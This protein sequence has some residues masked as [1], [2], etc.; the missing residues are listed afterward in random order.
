MT[1]EHVEYFILLFFIFLNGVYIL[2]LLFAWDAWM[3]SFDIEK[4]NDSIKLLRSNNFPQISFV[5]PAFNEE[6]VISHNV[7]HL[8]N[9]SYRAVEIIVVNDGST[10]NMLPLMIQQ[11]NMVLAPPIREN[12]VPCQPIKAIYRSLTYPHLILV[13]KERGGRSD[14]LNG[15]INM[16]SSPYFIALDADTLVDDKEFNSLIIPLLTH[17]DTVAA[18][19]S[20]RVANGCHVALNRIVEFGFPSNYW[21]GIQCVEYLRSFFLG[22][23]GWS[24]MGGMFII[25]GAFGIFRTDIVIELKGYDPVIIAEDLDLTLRIHKKMMDSNTPYQMPFIPSPVAWTEVP[26]TFMSL[27]S[28]RERWQRGLIQGLWRHRDMLFNPR[29]GTLAFIVYPFYLFGEMLAPVVEF[30]GYVIIAYLLWIDQ[31]NWNFFFLFI[32]F[33]FGVTYILSFAS[34]LIEEMTYQKYHKMPNILKIL[35]LGTIEMFGYR[36]LTVLWRLCGFF[37]APISNVTYSSLKREGFN[38]PKK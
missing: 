16:V 2:Q 27:W 25:A 30:S 3:E 21:A 5:I 12:Q 37:P 36:Q 28:Q 29:Y 20:I 19:A 31:I 4:A 15:G 23:M 34:I 1:I 32:A 6:M 13:D 26:E 11:F 35:G 18:G 24:Q 9:L 8:L 38:K 10:D 33:A 7:H 14:A 22:R 17:P